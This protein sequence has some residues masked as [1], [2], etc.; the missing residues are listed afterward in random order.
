MFVSFHVIA[1]SR[2]CEH[3]EAISDVRNDRL[4]KLTKKTTVCFRSLWFQKWCVYVDL[5]LY[6]F[7]KSRTFVSE[8]TIF[9]SIAGITKNVW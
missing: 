5:G 4:A 1:R 2:S 7:P 3:S 8:A 6:T 9:L